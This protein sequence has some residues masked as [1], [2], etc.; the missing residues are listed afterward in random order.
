MFYVRHHT[1]TCI[2][3]HLTIVSW[4]H[5]LPGLP[6]MGDFPHFWGENHVG[7]GNGGDLTKMGE[8][9]MSF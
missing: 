4:Q 3:D 1:A 6:T 8:N 2:V 5:W 7:W 9:E